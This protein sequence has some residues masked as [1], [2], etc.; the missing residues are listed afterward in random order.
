MSS[1]KEFKPYNPFYDPLVDRNPGTGVGYAPSYWCATAGN[2]P[3]NDGQVTRDMDVDVAK[4][5]IY[6]SQGYSGN[7]VSFSA[8]AS[9]KMAGLIAGQSN[10]DED[11]PIFNSTLPRHFLRPFR[12]SGQRLLYT[13]FKYMDMMR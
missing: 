11:L 13:C 3:E 6:Y 5:K 9:F 7:G 10:H 8:Y 2:M 1:I 12:R 4:Q